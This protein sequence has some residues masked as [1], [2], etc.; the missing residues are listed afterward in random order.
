MTVKN[1]LL[2]LAA[3]GLAG[4]LLIS[5]VGFHVQRIAARERATQAVV[6]TALRNH[7]DGDMMHDA[8]RADVLAALLGARR[9]D[10]QAILDAQAELEEHAARFRRNLKENAG[11]SLDPEVKKLVMDLA[12]ALENYI[13]SGQA[14]T[15]LALV[16]PDQLDARLP[17]FLTAFGELEDAG[18]TLS[19]E[20][21]AVAD[22]THATLAEIESRSRRLQIGV[23]I[24]FGCL[25]VL[26]SV[27]L[28]RYVIR[29]MKTSIEVA[30]KVA[31][32]DLTSVIATDAADEFGELF[33][34]LDRMQRGL[35]ERDARDGRVAAENLRV[36][37]ALDM[38]SAPVMLVDADHTIVYQNQAAATMWR[39][40][41][42]DL[43]AVDPGFEARR[44]DGG[45]VQWIDASLDF[46]RTDTTER[47]KL[48]KG[49]RTFQLSA[50]PVLGAGGERL[51][52]VL[53]WHDRTAEIAVEE[54]IAALVEAAA[55]G[56]FTRRVDV[57][58][59]EGFFK[60]FGE[61]I[62]RL[63]ET[64]QT[65]LDDVLRVLSAVARGDLTEKMTR[66]YSGTFAALKHN[67]NRTI[68]H[69]RALIGDIQR[70]TDSIDV[71]AREISGGNADLA[72]RT[73]QQAASVEETAASMV[74]I[75]ATLKSNEETSQ[76]ANEFAARARDVAIQGGTVVGQVVA[77]MG[78]IHEA[79]RKITDIIGVIDDIAFQTNLLALNAAV[80]AA[81]AGE[82]GRG[83]AV[84]ASNVRVLAQRTAESAQE[85]K[86]LIGESVATVESGTELVERAGRTME[87]VVGSV[88]RISEMIAE[89][90][91]ASSEQSKGLSQIGNAITQFDEATQENA[92]LV[93]Q[94]TSAAQSLQKQSGM[95]TEK[96]NVFR[97]EGGRSSSRS[98]ERSGP[99]AVARP[100]RPFPSA[101][102]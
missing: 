35:A 73:R 26:L 27:A 99:R 10:R 88:K 25:Q 20:L 102:A 7:V 54:S 90:S 78:D 46:R 31:S 70:A 74:E 18:E 3:V 87:E 34:A 75:N 59:E 19:T 60:L 32:G 8:I 16:A 77:T 72:E 51:G 56:D 85:I 9:E 98:V 40:A 68:D 101:T 14:I 71:A 13:A 24:G 63:V 45:R 91:A 15:D 28:I 80:E 44:L 29:T 79:S 89:L 4:A 58:H 94:A 64:C 36:R 17:A 49:A 65:G 83:F 41:E 61:S 53:E 43:R 48:A 95:L 92:A 39:Q 37:R 69:L 5:G 67:T 38:A 50:G 6:E 57:S 86:A 76:Q 21:E 55:H 84:V 12:P 100:S 1:K 62:N 93:D 66:D 97:F 23:L 2:L 22:S 11:L 52:T 42:A 47:R 96:V 33:T 81:R 82:Q 30:D